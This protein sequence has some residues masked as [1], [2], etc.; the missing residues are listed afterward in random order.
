M[1]LANMN[2]A[3]KRL[4]MKLHRLSGWE[5]TQ[6]NYSTETKQK[7]DI[8]IDGDLLSGN[9]F[10]VADC[11]AYDLGYLLRKLPE[12]T[13]IRKKL[14]KY[15]ASLRRGNKVYPSYEADTPEDAACKLAIKLFKQGVLKK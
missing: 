13:L 10:E 11:P 7:K 8:T 15:E 12:P 14:G 1:N 3:S 2:F 9:I 6:F 5:D 4:C